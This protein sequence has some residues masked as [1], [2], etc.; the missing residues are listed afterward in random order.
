MQLPR[1]AIGL[2]KLRFKAPFSFFVMQNKCEST[3]SISDLSN[4]YLG[5]NK[6]ASETEQPQV[7]YVSDPMNPSDILSIAQELISLM[8][9]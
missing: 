5:P 2:C 3:E 7:H 8:T 1:M 4:P 9:A 6:M